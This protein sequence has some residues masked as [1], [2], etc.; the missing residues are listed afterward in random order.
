MALALFLLR[1]K[2]KKRTIDPEAVLL[3]GPAG[4]FLGEN[5][6]RW[7][8][9]KHPKAGPSE[10]GLIDPRRA[11]AVASSEIPVAADSESRGPN[12]ETVVGESGV[13]SF[14]EN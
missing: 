13:L 3:G 6:V 2:S 7:Y 1:Y 4:L 8:I 14:S 11:I 5:F 9:E 10:I 12:M